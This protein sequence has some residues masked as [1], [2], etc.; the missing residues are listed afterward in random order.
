MAGKNGRKERMH[1]GERMDGGIRWYY[2]IFENVKKI[3]EESLAEKM[4]NI[5]KLIDEI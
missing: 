3:K 5:E 4:H 1:S 2:Y